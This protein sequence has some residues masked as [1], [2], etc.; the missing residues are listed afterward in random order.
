MESEEAIS[1]LDT[2]A[3]LDGLSDEDLFAGSSADEFRSDS[4]EN[5]SAGSGDDQEEVDFGDDVAQPDSQPTA[6][7]GDQPMDM[8][9]NSGDTEAEE[10]AEQAVAAAIAASSSA[11]S[12][13]NRGRGRARGRSA[14]TSRGRG[15]GR[16]ADAPRGASARGRGRGHGR[17]RGRGAGSVGAV[18]GNQGNGWDT[19]DNAV[20]GNAP[21]FNPAR[22]AGMHLPDDIACTCELDF[23]SLF[24]T[25]DVFQKLADSTNL[26]AWQHIEKFP[27]YA[28]KFGAWPENIGWRD[29]EMCWAHRVHEPCQV[30]QSSW[31]LAH[32]IPISWPVGPIICSSKIT[33]CCVDDLPACDGSGSWK[34]DRQTTQ[35]AMAEWSPEVQVQGIIPAQPAD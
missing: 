5:E 13:A 17:G 29:E 6:A 33:V 21:E 14:S 28:D 10:T 27:Y 20:S 35:S 7:G 23:F 30:T 32:F 22:D 11:P 3:D 2:A 34:S 4:E 8:E 24:F 19:P 1:F 12:H 26:Y 31:L 25:D 9:S 15:R 18:Q 16:S